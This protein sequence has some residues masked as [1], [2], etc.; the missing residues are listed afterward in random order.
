MIGLVDLGISNIF[1]IRNALKYLGYKVRLI[2][3]PNDFNNIKSLILPGVGT[4]KEGMVALEKKKLTSSLIERVNKGLP[5]LGICLGMQM[6]ASRGYENGETRGLN[7]IKGQVKKLNFKKNYPVP[8]IGWCDVSIKRDSILFESNKAKSFY[9]LHSYYFSCSEKSSIVA[10]I[11]FA[12]DNIPVVINKK[13]IF[14]IQYHPE[15]SFENG[16]DNLN[17]FIKFL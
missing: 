14:G 15:K 8:N 11:K 17:R 3:K 1:S 6:L 12:D 4:F 2:N 7:L 9:F 13:N 10:T 16:I 5:F